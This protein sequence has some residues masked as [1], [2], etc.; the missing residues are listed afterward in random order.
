M[1]A[2]IMVKNC[3]QKLYNNIDENL[4]MDFAKGM[5]NKPMT[6]TDAQETLNQFR[7]KNNRRNINNNNSNNNNNNNSGKH[8]IYGNQSTNSTKKPDTKP[9]EQKASEQPKRSAA[10]QLLLKGGD[11][12][13]SGSGFIFAQ[14][15]HRN[16]ENTLRSTV[17][18]DHDGAVNV[19]SDDAVSRRSMDVTDAFALA[20][21]DAEIDP[22]WILLD[23]QATC[24]LI[25]NPALVKNIMKEPNGESITL[26][27]NAGTVVIDTIATLPGFGIVWFYA[28]G[29]A[30]ILSL[31]LVSD[32]YRVT[33]DTENEQ[34]FF[35]HKPD[36]STRKFKRMTCNLYAC[37]IAAFENQGVVLTVTAEGKKAEYSNKD[38]K[39]ADAARQLQEI[40]GYPSLKA[41]LKMIDN[42]LIKNCTVTRRDVMMA[43][44]IYGVHPNIVKGKSVRRQP[45]QVREEILSVPPSILKKLQQRYHLY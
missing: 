3:N 37:N 11:D 22:L 9:P 40:L 20:E 36:G 16:P 38:V 17:L 24:N 29:I 39:R 23:S 32:R 31:G 27:C 13:Y 25:C 8:N 45:G 6:V 44:D 19:L 33:L 21:T 4:R 1:M 35:V 41:Y 26:H 34:A 42:N 30:N 43:E 18:Q 15:A 28:G 14:M 2:T 5:D 7:V 10:H 12:I